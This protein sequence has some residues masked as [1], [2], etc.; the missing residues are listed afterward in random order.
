MILIKN[1]KVIKIK[2][3]LSYKWEDKTYVDGFKGMI[4]NPNTDYNHVGISERKNYKQQ[5][6]SAI[7]RY[8]RGL[9]GEADALVCLIGDNTH[10]SKWID[11]ELSVANSQQK[12]IIPVRI[13]G[14]TGGLPQLLKG[15]EEVRW[16]SREINNALSRL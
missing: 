14:T 1:Q 16:N 15:Q 13:K 2:L 5:G 4:E 9:I 12:K 10:N 3:F 6:E 11:Y 7:R 8:L